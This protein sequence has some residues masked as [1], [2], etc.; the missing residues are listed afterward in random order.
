MMRSVLI[1]KILAREWE[2]S[3]TIPTCAPVREIAGCP[4]SW[5]A[6]LIRAIVTCSPV[7]KSISIS[8]RLGFWEISRAKFTKASVLL[9][10]ADT[11]TTTR[12][13]RSTVACTLFA[14]A[15]IFS[16]VPTDVPPYFWTIS[17]ILFCYSLGRDFYFTL[18]LDRFGFLNK[19]S[20][21]MLDRSVK[22]NISNQIN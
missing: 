13:P 14:T 20:K 7:D 16:V 10:I 18:P 2:A 12:L 15:R 22:I 11:T 21:I 4:N 3:V 5:S 6:I 19:I 17:T 1:C 9:P 8:L